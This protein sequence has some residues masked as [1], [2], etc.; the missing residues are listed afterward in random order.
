MLQD[1]STKP[2]PSL[3]VTNSALKQKQSMSKTGPAEVEDDASL[4]DVLQTDQA[5]PRE[6]LLSLWPVCLRTR[7]L[8]LVCALIRRLRTKRVKA[9]PVSAMSHLHQ[10]LDL[11]RLV[12]EAAPTE[13]E[14]A[15]NCNRILCIEAALLIARTAAGQ[16]Q[17]HNETALG[18]LRRC[19]SVLRRQPA[20][21]ECRTQVQTFTWQL[22][23]RSDLNQ[24]ALLPASKRTRAKVTPQRKKRQ[25]QDL[26]VTATTTTTTMT[27]LTTT[28]VSTAALTRQRQFNLR[29]AHVLQ[30][31]RGH[32]SSIRLL[33]LLAL[34]IL[35]PGVNK[36]PDPGNSIAANM[37]AKVALSNPSWSSVHVWQFLGQG[38]RFR[39]ARSS[40]EMHDLLVFLQ[41]VADA[42]ERRHDAVSR[43][44]V[45][46]LMSRYRE[47]ALMQ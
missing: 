13:A 2:V 45:K 20:P 12:E 4:S 33:R 26:P 37:V 3:K 22:S 14:A 44:Q 6:A 19:L 47:A 24:A 23:R 30:S 39:Q 28:S 10:S 38:L 36:T 27:K 31:R 15:D 7:Q 29:L 8:H 41:L 1:G 32:R 34:K 9:L 43:K 40:Q 11:V 5:I 35:Q 17:F 16:I 18:V 21:Q 46:A 25:V 42:F